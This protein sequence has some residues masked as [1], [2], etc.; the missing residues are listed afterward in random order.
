MKRTERMALSHTEQEFHRKIAAEC[1]NKTWD[2]LE[3]KN[4]TPKDD[5]SMLNLAHSS[6]Y[7]WS[8]VG[9]ARN[10]TVG[11][12]QISRVYSALNQPDLAVHFAK[13]SLETCQKNDLSELLASAYE[14]VARAYAVAKEYATAKEYVDKARQQLR[15]AVLDAEDVKTFSD[16]ID[17]TERMIGK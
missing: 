9:N 13:T 5:E 8:F 17:E 14:G 16:Q 7:H 15:G 12:W 11:D 3:K 6:R 1:F 2:Y 10:F 4:R